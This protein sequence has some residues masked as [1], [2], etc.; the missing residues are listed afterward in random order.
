[1]LKY[2][3]LSS[4]TI[5]ELIDMQA[6][7]K[8]ERFNLRLKQNL[9]IIVSTARMRACRREIARIRTCMHALKA[10]K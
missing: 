10:K 7:R 6:E 3:E 1:M 5:S 4:K 2:S 8:K 9:G